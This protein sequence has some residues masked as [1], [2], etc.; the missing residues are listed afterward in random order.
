MEITACGADFIKKNRRRN[1]SAEQQIFLVFHAHH[2][3]EAER[4]MKMATIKVCDFCGEKIFDPHEANLRIFYLEDEVI[5]EQ[6]HLFPI[7]TRKIKK[8]T[9][10]IEVDLCGR[11]WEELRSCCKGE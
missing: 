7:P 8:E 2:V 6:K 10:F 3:V 11:C 5:E 9:Q 1:I 4:R